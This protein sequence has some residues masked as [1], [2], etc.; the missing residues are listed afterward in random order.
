MGASPASRRKLF[1]A[2]GGLVLT[3]LVLA[4]GAALMADGYRPDWPMTG[5]M[6]ASL[7]V[8]SR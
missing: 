8:L 4:A 6:V 3:V 2:S 5:I 1:P 7:M